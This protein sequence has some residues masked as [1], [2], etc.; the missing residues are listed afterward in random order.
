M[1]RRAHRRHAPLG[2]SPSVADPLRRSGRA[3]HRGRG[4]RGARAFARA[5]RRAPPV[6]GPK[7]ACASSASRRTVA[8][9]TGVSCSRT[10]RA[11][12]PG[13]SST[14]RSALPRRIS[15]RSPSPRTR[16]SVWAGNV[17]ATTSPRTTT[18]SADP[19][20]ESACTASR[21][22]TLPWTSAKAAMDIGRPYL[23]P[24]CESFNIRAALAQPGRWWAGPRPW[25]T[26]R[27][28]CTRSENVSTSRPCAPSCGSMLPPPR[29]ARATL[30][31]R[32]TRPPGGMH[33]SGACHEL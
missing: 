5:P 26:P 6:D 10:Q 21:A 14:I 11:S 33:V 28:R 16:S 8:S 32:S 20:R 9:C 23:R 7:E 13:S 4:R 1:R 12:P 22:W 31:E 18:R 17:P 30:E 25:A 15:A 29:S 19:N 2:R 24:R 27:R 3:A